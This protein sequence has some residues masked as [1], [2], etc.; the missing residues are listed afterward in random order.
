MDFETIEIALLAG[1]IT[2]KR[3]RDAS[4]YRRVGVSEDSR[5]CGSG[6]MIAKPDRGRNSPVHGASFP[7]PKASAPGS[8]EECGEREHIP[9]Q[10]QLAGTARAVAEVHFRRNADACFLQMRGETQ[11]CELGVLIALDYLR[12][13]LSQRG[14][15]R[16]SRS[17][18]L[19]SAS[20]APFATR[21][22]VRKALPPCVVALSRCGHVFC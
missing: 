4:A 10:Q 12:P 7:S 15:Q 22:S 18:Q 19:F 9:A 21:R 5:L 16:I 17:G 2:T 14:I 1:D 3:R 11:G 8:E 20:P 13:T 6:P